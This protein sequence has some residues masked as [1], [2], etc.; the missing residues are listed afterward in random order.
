MEQAANH[1]DNSYIF[2][3]PACFAISKIAYDKLG[4]PSFK[5]SKL[6]DTAGELTLAARDYR[7][8]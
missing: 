5:S 1:I 4:K 8:E 7:F 6:V 2:A 3:G